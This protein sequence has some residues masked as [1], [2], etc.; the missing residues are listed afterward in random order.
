MLTATASVPSEPIRNQSSY[1]L[2][3]I[4]SVPGAASPSHP[5][6]YS[7]DASTALLLP[8]VADRCAATGG[9]MNWRSWATLLP[10][11]VHFL[12]AEDVSFEAF[13]T[14]QTAIAASFTHI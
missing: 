4:T 3:G 14:V 5:T 12:G 9:T 2:L 1:L 13:A 11:A 7:V 6:L 8:S 10:S